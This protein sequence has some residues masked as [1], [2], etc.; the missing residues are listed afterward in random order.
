VRN[1]LD[2]VSRRARQAA[3]EERVDAWLEAHLRRRRGGR[4]HP[5]GNDRQQV[6]IAACAPTIKLMPRGRGARTMEPRHLRT[7]GDEETE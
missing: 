3:H 7:L 1:V 6:A 4:K 2:E 5:V